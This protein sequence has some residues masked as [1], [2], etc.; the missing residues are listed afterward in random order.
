[1]KLTDLKV[2][3]LRLSFQLE[4]ANTA[5]YKQALAPDKC[6]IFKGVPWSMCFMFSWEFSSTSYD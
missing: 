3:V 6:G 5:L 2:F 1:M 4:V